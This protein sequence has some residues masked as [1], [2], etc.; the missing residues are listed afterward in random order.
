MRQHRAIW[1]VL[2]LIVT[3][4]IPTLSRASTPQTDT[5]MQDAE[6]T[7]GIRS[8]EALYALPKRKI[9]CVRLQDDQYH[10]WDPVRRS[11]SKAAPACAPP[12]GAE[13][14]RIPFVPL[15]AEER[16]GDITSY[17]SQT[18]FPTGGQ[19][20]S[21]VG[22]TAVRCNPNFSTYYIK[23][24]SG[25]QYRAFYLVAR[26]KRPATVTL[27]R[28]C[29]ASGGIEE[30]V[31]QDVIDVSFAWPSISEGGGLFCT[32]SSPSSAGRSF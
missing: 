7:W 29:E 21:K 19:S 10:I 20:I 25:G 16:S 15:V 4:V 31:V 30:S 26:L 5:D 12:S 23:K 14:V 28:Y 3:S 24:V 13:P 9:L 27:G 18:G 11:M 2:V 1:M 17:P 32:L 22:S 6:A 8:I